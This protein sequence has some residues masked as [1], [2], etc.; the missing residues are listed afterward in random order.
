MLTIAM[1]LLPLIF[2]VAH[3]HTHYDP[4]LQIPPFSPLISVEDIFGIY[5]R[6]SM[7]R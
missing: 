2:S 3:A 7:C 6:V 5:R 1:M 4:V